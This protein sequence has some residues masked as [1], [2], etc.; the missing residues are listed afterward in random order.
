[1]IGND[2]GC[3]N[4]KDNFKL[5]G[6]PGECK[7]NLSTKKGKNCILNVMSENPVTLCALKINEGCAAC[8]AAAAAS[9]CYT[10]CQPQ[11]G[12][13]YNTACG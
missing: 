1:M 8:I 13:T 10:K 9:W 11:A 6:E 7:A 4:S 2:G 12:Q 3:R 5:V